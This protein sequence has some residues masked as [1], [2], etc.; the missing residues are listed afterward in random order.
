MSVILLEFN[1]EDFA[2]VTLLQCTAK[3]FAWNFAET[4]Y[5]RNSQNK[6]HTKFKAFTVNATKTEE[7]K[8]N[9]FTNDLMTHYRHRVINSSIYISTHIYAFTVRLTD[10]IILAKNIPQAQTGSSCLF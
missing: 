6:S 10:S 5:A 9:Y 3:T 1:F 8:I 4:V 7:K 2:L